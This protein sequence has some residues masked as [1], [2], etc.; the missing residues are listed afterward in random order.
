MA[1][2]V[3]KSK[4]VKNFELSTPI[5][6]MDVAKNPRDLEYAAQVIE[7]MEFDSEGEKLKTRRGLGS[8]IQTFDADIL[9]VWYDYGM[10]NYVIFLKNKKVYTYEYGKEPVFIGTFTGDTTHRPQLARFTNANGTKLLMAVGGN[11][12]YYEYNGT[13]LVT[14]EKY[15]VCDTLMERFS[16]VVVAESSNNNIK[17]SGIA[18]PLNWTE[19][20]N[21]ASAMKDLDVGDVSGVIGLYPLASELI[22][23]KEN[24]RIYRIANEPEDWN[25]TLV[26]TDSDFLSRDAMSNIGDDVVYFSRQGL[27]SLAAST[28]YGNFTNDETGEAM[29]PEMKK[30]TSDPWIF[31]SQRT[32]QLF[33]NPNNK[34]TVYVYHYQLKAFTK[35]IFP[36][37]INSIVEGKE[38]TLVASGRELFSLSSENHTDV[39]GGKETKIHQRLVSGKVL[40]LNIMTLYRSHIM[41]DSNTA[42]TAKLTVNDVTWDWNWTEGNQREEFKT[43]IRA[44]EMTMTFETDDIITWEFWTAVIV[45][46]Y[47]TM[48]SGDS[49]GGSS[50]GWGSSNKKGWGQGTF[51]GYTGDSGGSPYG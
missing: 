49:S 13:S 1:K 41:I 10:N 28:T 44:D 26:G 8:P 31:K 36:K 24:G 34:E 19:N 21:D 29:N 23:F 42:G 46:Q 27:R 20:S 4:R 32:H 12:H 5:K 30:D 45:F 40:D 16:R 48:V 47:V 14:D 17:Y 43:Q 7:N 37:P 50:G 35:W 11:M 6:G 2:Q 3:G 22:C 15:P 39:V 33:I 51:E 38:K 18:D 25:V 9:Y